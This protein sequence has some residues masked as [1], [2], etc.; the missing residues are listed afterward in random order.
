MVFTDIICNIC[1]FDLDFF[2]PDSIEFKNPLSNMAEGIITVYYQ[3]TSRY[4]FL[5]FYRMFWIVFH[6]L[7]TFL[8]AS[9]LA[10]D[11]LRTA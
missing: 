1:I 2:S 9:L 8:S 4:Q 11:K 10:L 6:V 5:T 7:A 3:S